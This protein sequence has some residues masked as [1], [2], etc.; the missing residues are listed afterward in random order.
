M[1]DCAE[2]T[3]RSPSARLSFHANRKTSCGVFQLGV[4][5][6]NTSA[7]VGTFTLVSPLRVMTRLKAPSTVGEPPLDEER[8]ALHRR[9]EGLLLLRRHRRG[10]RDEHVG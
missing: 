5:N 8:V 3:T 7:R 2:I 9:A 1:T 4:V 6:F 10:D